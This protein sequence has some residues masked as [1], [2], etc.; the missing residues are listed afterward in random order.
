MCGPVFGQLSALGE[1]NIC[2]KVQKK[3]K[4]RGVRG[5]ELEKKP[6]KARSGTHV[7]KVD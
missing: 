3:K 6:C 1:K 7:R 2:L 5:K 4:N